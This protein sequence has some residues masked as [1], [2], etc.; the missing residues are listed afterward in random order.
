MKMKANKAGFIRLAL[1]VILVIAVTATVYAQDPV[2]PPTNLGLASVYDG[3]AGK[4]GLVFQG[5]LQ[6]FQTR[7]LYGPN[8]ANTPSDLKVN[9]VLQMDQVLYLAPIKVLDGNLG[10]TI[11][12]PIVQISASSVTTTAPATNPGVLGDPITGVAIQWSDKKLFG[13]PFSH[14]LEFD[15]SVPLG[16][17]DSRYAINPSAHLW[18]Y[19]IYHALTLTLDKKISISARN[20]LNY[21]THIIGTEAKPGAFYNGSYSIDYSILPFVKIEAVSYFLTQLIQDSYDG[22]HHYYQDRYGIPDTKERVFACGPGLVYFSP[23]GVLFEGKV[24]FETGGQNRFV[25]TRTSLRV[26]VSLSK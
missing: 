4:P 20:E 13:K 17:F 19:E 9:S 26:V 25:G 5:Y 14:R 6:A 12:I 1:S 11:L 22:N 18:S 10:F 15:L 23:K 24:F 2:L 3:V 16:N 8:G 21:N 7:S